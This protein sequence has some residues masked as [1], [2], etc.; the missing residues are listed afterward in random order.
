L[1]EL[2]DKLGPFPEDLSGGARAVSGDVL[3]DAREALRNLGYTTT[4]SAR[5]LDGF[6]GEGEPAVEELLRHALT[7]L[8]RE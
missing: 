3:R 2:K 5:A 8:A 7:R 6:S 4:E 1:M